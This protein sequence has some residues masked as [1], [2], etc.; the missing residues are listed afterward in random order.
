MRRFKAKIIIN[1]SIEIIEELAKYLKKKYPD[2]SLS[3]YIESELSER[4]LEILKLVCEG[5]NNK[6]ISNRLHI[7]NYTVTAHLSRVCEKLC[8]RDRI[9]AVIKALRENII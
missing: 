3:F 4:E 6:E 5:K 2:K 1:A 8:V 7:S 9:Q